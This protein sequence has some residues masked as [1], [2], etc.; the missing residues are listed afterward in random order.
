MQDATFATGMEAF[1]AVAKTCDVEC[2]HQPNVKFHRL[3]CNKS[4][5]Q[6]HGVCDGVCMRLLAILAACVTSLVPG[7]AA[8]ADQEIR[9]VRFGGDEART[10][11]VVETSQPGEFRAYTL[12]GVST[13]L[14]VDLPVSSWD[15]PGL[16]AG[17]G[18]GT[19]LVDGF[20]FFNNSSSSSRIVFELDHPAMVD[21]QFALEPAPNSNNYRIVVDLARTSEQ[22]FRDSA[23]VQPVAST[24]DSLIAERVEAVYVPPARERR[25]IVLDAGHG[26]H[27]PGASGRGGTHE[28][29]VTLSAARELRRQLESTG[30]YEVYLTRDTDVFLS[31][32]QR[33]QVAADVRADLFLSIHAD[34]VPTNRNARGAAVYTLNDRAENR[35]RNRAL[36]SASHSDE[37]DVN[38]ILVSL[39]LREKRNQSSAFAEV[40]LEHLGDSGPLLNNPHRQENFYVLLDSRVPAVLLEMGFL[41]NSTDERNLNSASHR[42]RQME[43]VTRGIDDYFAT[44]GDMGEYPEAANAPIRAR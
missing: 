4:R 38:N 18:M 17:E 41:S 25:V 21:S 31:L 26:G 15:V 29:D 22:A 7:A 10:R 27:D 39:E 30:R 42:R 3:G 5:G 19:G 44:R 33:V 43:A 36:Q 23:G 20:R 13:R 9:A 12:D 16:E 34:S 6:N 37:V 1:R 8:L 2:F 28:R 32:Q 14:V 35:A 40:L 24:M 11:V